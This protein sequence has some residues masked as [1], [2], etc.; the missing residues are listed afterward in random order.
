MNIAISGSDA[1]LPCRPNCDKYIVCVEG[2][3]DG[4]AVYS[5]ND[6]DLKARSHRGDINEVSCQF[7]AF[8]AQ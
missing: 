3:Y 7:V 8:L 4:A 2:A 5:A 6:V 1:L